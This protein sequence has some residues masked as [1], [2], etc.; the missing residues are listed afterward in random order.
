MT[1]SAHMEQALG[2]A[3]QLRRRNV[4][5]LHHSLHALHLIGDALSLLPLY[6]P[7][8]RQLRA[9]LL[10]RRRKT[11]AEWVRDREEGDKTQ[12]EQEKGC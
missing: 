10:R 8:P 9:Y 3:E 4:E 12:L 7:T 2:E 6:V 5:I 1:Y 11:G